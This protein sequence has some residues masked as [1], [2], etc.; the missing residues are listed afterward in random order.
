MSTSRKVRAKLA[1]LRRSARKATS[2]EAARKEP[3]PEPTERSTAETQA[4]TQRGTVTASSALTGTQFVCFCHRLLGQKLFA[5]LSLFT[6]T[7]QSRRQARRAHRGRQ[8]REPLRAA[9][10][11]HRNVPWE[12]PR[13]VG[14]VENLAVC[15]SHSRS[16]I[17]PN[18]HFFYPA[19]SG[20]KKRKRQATAD[21]DSETTSS[22]DSDSSSTVDTS[23]SEG[24]DEKDF[25]LR[26]ERLRARGHPHRESQHGLV[27]ASH[28]GRHTVPRRPRRP[29]KYPRPHQPR[30]H[31]RPMLD[32]MLP[33][34]R[35]YYSPR[36]QLSLDEGMIPTKNRLTIKQYIRD[37]PVRWGIKSFL[38]CE[39]KTGY[40]LEAEI[41][42]GR[43][44]DR[45]WPLLGSAGSVVRRLVENSQVTNK[46]H[47]LF[48]DRFYNSDALFHLLKNE[49]GVLAAGT[50]MR[51][52]KHY[53]KEL[54]RRLTERGR[55]EFWCRGALCAIAWKDRKAI[56]FL[57]NYHDL[58]R[59]STVN[60]RVGDRLAQLTAPQLVVDYTR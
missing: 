35:R 26:T 14:S 5:G 9:S 23:T 44:K 45:H 46:N 58:R 32:R 59:A 48:M 19:V 47:M 3:E 27:R 51:S 8:R 21:P 57:S 29:P 15:L 6:C 56:H 55:Y 7:F 28:Q 33:L 53:P 25:V 16:E 42:T 10:M 49:L 36:Q 4:A 31:R 38:L 11:R 60:R 2:T 12:P 18:I 41:Y 20:P 17:W 22:S 43:V 40:I 24:E 54:G 52:R 34:F 50:V 1:K 13:Q 37:K 30:E 39:A